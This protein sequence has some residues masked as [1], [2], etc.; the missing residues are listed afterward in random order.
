MTVE[1]GVA[2]LNKIVGFVTIATVLA[3]AWYFYK[4][5]IW[6]PKIKVISVDYVK[7][8]ATLDVNGIKKTLYKNQTL[9]VGG[10]YGVRFNGKVE[11]ET[12][13]L[14]LYKNSLTYSVLDMQK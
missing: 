13:W 10:D 14:E 5:S 9:A 1:K 8:V 6:K 4:T 2:L 12:S 3:G 11:G 7:G